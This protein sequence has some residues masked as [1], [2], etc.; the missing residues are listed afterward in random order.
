MMT[1][2][3]NLIDDG[4]ITQ[5]QYDEALHNKISKNN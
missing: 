3:Q 4:S 5:D 1:K 2:E